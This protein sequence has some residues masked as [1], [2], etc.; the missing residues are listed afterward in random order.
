MQRWWLFAVML[1]SGF[2]VAAAPANA[3][4]KTIPVFELKGALTEKPAA[5]DF[6]FGPMDVESFRHLIGRLDKAAADTK[7]PAVVILSEGLELGYGQREEL[8]AAMQRLRAAGKK[9]YAHADWM[10]TGGYALISGADRL[11]VTPT[12]YL[13]VTGLYGEQPYLRGLLDRLGVQP[14]FVT[15]GEYKS[16]AEMFMRSSPSPKAAEMYKWLYD[17]LYDGTLQ[18][19]ADGRKVDVAKARKW[20]DTGLYS[21]EH[22]LQDGLIDAVEYRNEFVAHIESE[23]GPGVVFDKKYGKKQAATVDLNNPFAVMQF[24]MQLLAG[25]QTK[26]STKDAVAVIYV[27][28]NILPGSPERSPFSSSEGAYGDPIRKAI[29]S[30]AEDNTI[31]AVVLRVDSP[32]GSAV[33][34]EVIL[35]ACQRLSAKKPLIVSMGNVAASGGYYVTLA[36]KT[37]FADANTIT[38]SIGVLGGKL[39]TTDMWS[40][41]GVT[42]NPIE[43]GARAGMLGTSKIF[44]DDERQHFQ[45]WMDEVYAVFKGHVT[46]IR[47]EKLKQ[48]IDELAGGRVFT[49]RQA[50]ERGLVDELGTLKDAIDRAAKEAGLTTYEVRD[51]PPPENFL[52]LLLGDASGQENEMK[53]RLSLAVPG[54]ASASLWDAVLPMLQGVDPQRV[55]ILRGAFQQLELQRTE[56]VLLSAPM[57]NVHLP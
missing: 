18:L 30:A 56:Q 47:G 13:F 28:G 51:V 20:I 41:I 3:A 34:S 57:F 21:A 31:K 2:A 32:G 50:L 15:C 11:S 1:T 36:S 48:P 7:V 4:G 14:D 6:P 10:M 55:R 29:D 9:V 26:K 42:W 27:E 35:Q 22:A 53:R 46:T 49:G 43:R 5:E 33:A 39:S 40:K 23:F 54:A 12:G 24:Y 37:V 8:R 25:P 45:T 44:S 17:G 52:E 19:I 38:G 16:A